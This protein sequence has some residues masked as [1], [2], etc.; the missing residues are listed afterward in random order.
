MRG[1]GRLIILSFCVCALFMVLST[2]AVG[3][4]VP[5]PLQVV[6]TLPDYAT[7]TKAIGGERVSVTQIVQGDQ[8][9]HFI[10]PKPSFVNM[11][12]EAD[13]LVATGLDLELWLSTVVDKSGNRRVRSGQVGYVATSHGMALL[14]KPAS[15]SR[16]EGGVHIYGNP[17]VTCSPLQMRI[18]SRNITTGLI[19]NDPE[20]K[21]IYQ[22]NLAVFLGEMDER[23][24]GKRLVEILGGDTL[25]ALAE[26][27]T[28]I[29]FLEE[30]DLDGAPLVDSL[31]GWMRA[32]LPIRG[33]A[34]VTY[35][36]NWVYFLKLFGME[37]AGTV[38]PKP[39]IPPSPRH[40]TEL[41]EMMR[42]RDIRIIL[43]ANYFDE[44]KIRTVASRVDAEAVIVPLY[45]GGEPEVTDY[46][47]LVDCW[48]ERLLAAA[49]AKGLLDVNGT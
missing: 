16:A 42:G 36:K 3:A 4:N 12:R 29:P 38:E 9:A 19:K 11:V 2:T 24:F 13:V 7:F 37:E 41:V 43:A 22:E 35:H 34:I 14:E 10:R 21:E 28:L 1:V 20:G 17:H 25:T 8:D 32:M 46:F 31:G 47:E 5:A 45:V 44:Q 26:K 49:K 6:A 23:L 18:A 15:I 33:T 48:I 40:V 39:G 27:G 30:Q